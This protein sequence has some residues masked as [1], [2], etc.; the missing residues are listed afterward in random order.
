MNIE[1]DFKTFVRL[2]LQQQTKTSCPFWQQQSTPPRPFIF[3]R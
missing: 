2:T 3:F 1:E